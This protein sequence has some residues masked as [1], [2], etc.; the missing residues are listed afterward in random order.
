MTKGKNSETTAGVPP[1]DITAAYIVIG[2]YVPKDEDDQRALFELPQFQDWLAD[3]FL[4]Q[5]KLASRKPFCETLLALLHP[6][7]SVTAANQTLTIKGVVDD[8]K[9]KLQELRAPMTANY[10]SPPSEINGLDLA[11][12]REAIYTAF[13][14]KFGSFD[15]DLECYVLCEKV[16]GAAPPPTRAAATTAVTPSV[17]TP[18]TT[19]TNTVK[20]TP[21]VADFDTWLCQVL[22]YQKNIRLPILKAILNGSQTPALTLAKGAIESSDIVFRI[23]Q[24]DR[25]LLY[26]L[27]PPR[28]SKIPADLLTQ[29][30]NEEDIKSFWDEPDR[31]KKL[32]DYFNERYQIYLASMT[33]KIQQGGR[34]KA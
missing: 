22:N 13:L 32:R 10:L 29:D 12:F 30:I 27:I 24:A 16:S 7:I 31:R 26:D 11:S 17:S 2:N 3:F 20:P 28:L 18:T 1:V 14:V 15:D 9:A 6:D 8:F 23:P 33:K 25:W 34:Q 19:L 4:N 21:V 5:L